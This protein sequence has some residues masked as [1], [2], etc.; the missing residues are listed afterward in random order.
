MK[1][2]PFWDD[3]TEPD[4]DH[5]CYMTS[6][7]PEDPFVVRLDQ[8]A[9]G[10]DRTLYC[11]FTTIELPS[12]R[13]RIPW[14]GERRGYRPSDRGPDFSDSGTQLGQIFR[15]T[16]RRNRDG[17]PQFTSATLLEQTPELQF[18]FASIEV[19]D[20][21]NAA[22]NGHLSSELRSVP[23]S[24]VD[25]YFNA[26]GNLFDEL[27]R[28]R[29]IAPGAERALWFAELLRDFDQVASE[30]FRWPLFRDRQSRFDAALQS[31]HASFAAIVEEPPA[32]APRPKSRLPTPGDERGALGRAKLV[33]CLPEY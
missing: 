32:G 2:I 30:L 22:V 11:F 9:W 10:P 12:Y 7:M 4:F 14:S 26:A 24:V 13:L 20:A 1:K 27:E 5:G 28:W 3:L 25:G 15:L 31:L 19:L 33:G 21:A 6:G 18:R 23:S 29:D 17:A 8:L 16:V